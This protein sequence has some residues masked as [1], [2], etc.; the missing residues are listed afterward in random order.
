MI[1]IYK[2]AFIV[3]LMFLSSFLSAQQN[4]IWSTIDG[5]KIGISPH[6][7]KIQPKKYKT[8]ELDLQHLR[9]DLNFARFDKS[10]VK[11]SSALISFPDEKGEFI[12]FEITEAPVMHPLLAEKYPNNRSFRG[13]SV[14][15]PSLKI[16]F[17]LTELGLSAIIMDVETGHT[18]IEPISA[19][20]NFYKV[21]SQ[22]ALEGIKDLEC[23]TES[24]PANQFSYKNAFNG[25]D[26]GHMKIY[27]LAL[28]ANGEYS[29][30]QLNDQNATGGDEISKKSVVMG[31]LTAAVTRVNAFLER[32]L[33][34]S[35]QL[36][37]NND[38]LIFLEP[39]QDPFDNNL[40]NPDLMLGQNQATVDKII[41]RSNYD[42]GHVFS[43]TG[44]VAKIRSA[45]V[46][47][48]KAQGVSGSLE[49]VGNT[50]YLDVVCHEIGHQLG[51]NHTFNG[52][53]DACAKSGQ[54]IEATAV[55]P[56][57]GSS[58]MS[59]AG[60][61]GSQNVQ[62][63]SDPYFHGLSLQ[64]INS[65]I[66][67][68]AIANCASQSVFITNKNPP[69]ASAGPD[70]ILPVGTPFKLTGEGSD[71]DMDQI[72]Y[73]WEQMD[74]GITAVPPSENATSGALYRSRIPS[75][76]AVRYF[77]NL[78]SLRNGGS[79]SKWEVIP[80]VARELNFRLTVRDNNIE[81]GQVVSDDVK[82]TITDQAGPFRVI[83]QNAEGEAW[84]PG[85][86][87]IVKWDV[88]GTDSNGINVTRVNIYLSTDGGFTYP[89]VLASNVSNNGSQ[90]IRV[91]EVQAP[92]CLVMIEAVG[93]TFFAINSN[94]FS[95]GAF[96]S[97]CSTYESKDIPKELI[98]GTSN[99][100]ISSSQVDRDDEIESITVSVKIKHSFIKDLALSL[101]SPEGT[102]V[103]LLKNPCDYNDEDI[104]AVFSDDGEQVYCASFSPTIV[105]N[106]QAIGEFSELNG[107]SAKG[108]WKLKVADES[109][110]DDGILEAWSMTIC[111]S[112]AVLAVAEN[113]L[114]NFQV[115]PN[116]SEGIFTVVF[117]SEESG[118]I[119]IS[120]HDLLG[121]K[122]HQKFYN[123]S[124]I[125]FE[126]V[127]NANVLKSG[128]YILKVR[129]GQKVS[130]RKLKIK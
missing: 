113:D 49:P 27:R 82:L 88:A 118:G 94:Q 124:S 76:E 126:E 85:T 19:D 5:A 110:G 8:F 119:D 79:S 46:E 35:L 90:N 12:V 9:N 130:F 42:I 55:E 18:L 51:A 54:R 81:G 15:D 93:S 47:G 38:A 3:C 39:G 128:I 17:S 114:D 111:T 106:Y 109:P 99:N 71:A 44:G 87:E 115:Y 69:K 58:I 97:I 16:R 48:I 83:S 68:G 63:N 30:F 33:A 127:F 62:S 107:E 89:T 98:F 101:E 112:K 91:P 72:T 31:T 65:F 74:A 23:F 123:E 80:Q 100:A 96:E 13:F 29:Q 61:C 56:G 37:A 75:L 28:S 86:Q 2:A 78:K 120:I 4:D 53:E 25:A 36:V 7:R 102:I 21:Y 70:L 32:D 14:A 105:G 60:Y 45:C 40:S 121:R 95:I 122:L 125:Q 52:S 108:Q 77:P 57:S 117:S 50:F 22:N 6:Q 59:Y 43:T 116:P 24:V 10:G 1:K 34:V 84:V 64:E 73:S 104:D 11:E 66:R 92:H 129:K 26:D 41:G 20:L 103:E 67:E